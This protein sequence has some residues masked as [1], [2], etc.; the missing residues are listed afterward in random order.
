MTRLAA[1]LMFLFTEV[2]FLERFRAAAGAGFRGVEYQF[3]YAH[4]SREVAA[5]L[6]DNGLEMVLQNLPPG[7]W[8]AGERGIACIP[9]REREFRDGVERAVDYA[10]AVGCRRLNCL[11]GILPAGIAEDRAHAT[12]LDNLAFAA[13]RLARDDLT[14]LVEAIN[15]RDMPGF[16]LSRSADVIG[17]I[18]EI[19]APNLRLQYDVYHMQVMEGDIVRTLRERI[20]YIGHVQ[21]ADNP[22]RHEP[23]TGELNVPFILDAL[24]AA[25]YRG[26]VSCEY[27]PAAGT[28]A[29]L[30]WARRYLEPAGG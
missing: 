25:G 11:A 7:D 10:L 2:D 29:G 28:V 23:G 17:I 20:D 15:T 8:E 26:W 3:P 5:R 12:L 14:L 24:D 19:G 1:N 16:Y 13:A 21:I 27:Q 9:E 6:A 18:D 4:A 30:G 22:G